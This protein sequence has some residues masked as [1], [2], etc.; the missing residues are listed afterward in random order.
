MFD[1]IKLLDKCEALTLLC[2]KAATHWSFIKFCFSIPLVITSSA[3]CII[4]SISTDANS[5]KIPN[6][7]VNAIS[8]LIISLNNNIKAGEKFESFK[9]LSQQFM[10]LSQEIEAIDE[11]I[12][13]EKVALLMLKYDNLINDTSFE[14]IPE[15]YKILVATKYT[16]ADRHV[17]I[18]INGVTGFMS[19]KK[20]NNNI[21]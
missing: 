12:T 4:N 18:Q 1:K 6:I 14:E 7:V 9:K 11:D 10:V 13:K 5:V 21:V 15:K 16:E 8:V 20:I 19:V 17:P 3:M 2:S